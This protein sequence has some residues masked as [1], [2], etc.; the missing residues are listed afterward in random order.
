MVWRYYLSQ[1]PLRNTELIGFPL[2]ISLSPRIQPTQCSLKSVSPIQDF[3]LIWRSALR[4]HTGG[5]D[6]EDT[7]SIVDLQ[8][9]INNF[10][11]ER[12]E[13]TSSSAA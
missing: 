8:E 6:A 2:P 11:Q 3:E 13:L 9:A 10:L 12:D 5:N 1:V 7:C 4:K